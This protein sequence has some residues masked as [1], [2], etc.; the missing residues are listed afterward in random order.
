MQLEDELAEPQRLFS[1][2][3]LSTR[4]GRADGVLGVGQRGGAAEGRRGPTP[5]CANRLRRATREGDA[6]T[7][8]GLVGADKTFWVGPFLDG[9][10]ATTTIA[11]TIDFQPAPEAVATGLGSSSRGATRFAVR[12][13][14]CGEHPHPSAGTAATGSGPAGPGQLRTPP[15]PPGQQ[16]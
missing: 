16:P 4:A 10:S 8:A 9:A 6:K 11:A 13:R 12:R 3:G 15:D 5:V 7:S 1:E 14:R 2:L